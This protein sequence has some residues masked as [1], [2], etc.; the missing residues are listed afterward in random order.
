M[1]KMIMIAVVLLASVMTASAQM[2]KAA[3][4]E[5]YAKQRYGDKWVDAAASLASTLTLDKNNSLTYRQ[6]FDAPGKTKSQLYVLM[7]YW[8]T[9]TFQDKQS[10][11]LN[12]KETGTI[13]INATMDNIV[14]HTGGLS[15]YSVSITPVIKI[16]IKDEKIRVT[17][18][19]Q[20]YDILRDTSGGVLG[21][22]FSENSGT[23]DDQN[24][25]KKDTT[26]R[27]LYDEKWELTTCY[28][29]VAKDEH[30]AKRTSSKALVMTHAYSS[31]IFDKIEEAIKN[32]I[33][34]DDG[35]D[36]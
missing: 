1:K 23:F 29:F 36:W 10:I 20:S 8:V 32:G 22:I 7:N 34:G 35:D 3:D 26:D 28:P 21:A 9:A 14:T 12:D 33:V 16:D 30:I 31:A 19:V 17:Y 18:T 13:I 15:Q 25:K 24:R 6:V 4:L 11:T 5:A 27:S 2:M